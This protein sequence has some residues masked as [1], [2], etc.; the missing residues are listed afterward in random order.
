MSFP[1][2]SGGSSIRMTGGQNKDE[3]TAP[4][5][6]GKSESNDNFFAFL[7]EAIVAGESTDS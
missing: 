4:P 1:V 2:H 6:I 3:F 7:D 5:G